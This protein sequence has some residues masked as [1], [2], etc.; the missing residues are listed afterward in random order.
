MIVFSQTDVGAR[1]ERRLAAIH[2]SKAGSGFEL[3]HGLLDRIMQVL[4]ILPLVDADK[5]SKTK[6]GNS[7]NNKARNYS[8]RASKRKYRVVAHFNESLMFLPNI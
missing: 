4:D 1:N 5:V 7:S 8:L 3:I 2:Y 6:R